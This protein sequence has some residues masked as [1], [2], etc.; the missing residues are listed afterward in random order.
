VAQQINVLTKTLIMLEQYTPGHSGNATEFMAARSLQTHGAF[1]RPYLQPGMKILDCGCGPGTIAAGLAEAVGSSGQV[2]GIDFAES[3]IALARNRSKANL[4]FEVA[5]VYRLPFADNTFDLVFSHALFEHLANPV[6]G[7]QELLRVL[8]PGGIAGLCSPDWGG[9]ILSPAN[10]RVDN[11]IGSY[12]AL[13]EKNGGDTLAGRKLASWLQE[14]DFS[15]EKLEARYECYPDSKV[16]A[17]YLA[18]QLERN[19]VIEPAAALREWALLPSSLFAQAWV[20][21][22]GLKVVE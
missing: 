13:Q 4:R 8:R 1:I 10:P 14:G 9:F 19:G 7:I 5:S 11:A 16:I 3:Q 20:S 18:I 2:I 17:E 15:V 21:A 12:R 6:R 22:I